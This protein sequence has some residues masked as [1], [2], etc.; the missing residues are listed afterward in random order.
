MKNE[1]HPRF[2]VPF[3]TS[4]L[5]LAAA[6]IALRYFYGKTFFIP[7]RLLAL[8]LALPLVLSWLA[9][10]FRRGIKPPATKSA[11]GRTDAAAGEEKAPPDADGTA[12]KN[13]TESAADSPAADFSAAE[14]IARNLSG[15]V[16]ADGTAVK[17]ATESAADSP[18]AGGAGGAADGTADSPVAGGAKP[19]PRHAR[20]KRA[21][22][23]FFAA[24]RRVRAA[25]IGAYNKCRGA[26]RVILSLGAIGFFSYRFFVLIGEKTDGYTMT[27]RYPVF[28]ALLF[29][30]FVI[31]EKWIRHTEP[32]D[33]FSG[34]L[35]R[36][37]RCTMGVGR[38]AILFFLVITVLRA[39]NIGNYQQVLIVAT[40]VIYCYQAVFLAVSFL[41]R[42]LKKELSDAPLYVV[43][44]PFLAGKDEDLGLL[45]YL[46]H[47]TG[48][49]MRGLWSVKLIRHILPYTVIAVV[50]LFWL[51]TGIVKVEPYQQGAVYRFGKLQD[52]ALS[53]GLHF[54]LPAPFDKVELYDT[55][56]VNKVTIGYRSEEAG[57]NTWT[58]AHGDEEYKLLLGSGDEVV[59]INLRLEY[60]ISDLHEYIRN[61]ACAECVLEALAYELVT[62]RTISTD[63]DTL[64]SVDRAAFSETFREELTEKLSAYRVG[65]EVVSVVLES[66][67]PPV[68][69]AETY[70]KLISAG[71]DAERY[72]LNTIGEC[73][74]VIANA[75]ITRA[76]TIGEAQSAYYSKVAAARG[77]VAE[78]MAA[79]AADTAYSDAYRY[80]KYLNAVS[81]AYNKARIVIV[82]EGV[83]MKNL[84]FGSLTLE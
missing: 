65:V 5:I 76:R 32:E 36:N 42:C 16:G 18:A 64:L 14:G 43:P 7:F 84:Y 33:A 55:E 26:L 69:I 30:V 27:L 52:A 50:M 11:P 2:S 19:H 46:E 9:L 57:D 38:L 21:R 60:K 17:N 8:T 79:V 29:V 82:G 75:Q 28:L 68:E 81:T 20:Q 13:A 15:A 31:L 78:F 22:A 6:L 41:I 58:A 59:S 47:N 3:L 51:S 49:T 53:P 61:S 80:Y 34:A 73:A 48:L 1:R 37:L 12:V 45:G 70:Q 67:H 83:N 4:S 40:A 74:T 72:R 63:L 25:L 66:I 23:W 54:V 71:I 62:D 10:L 24:A 39:M 77:E 35:L 44:I 56:T